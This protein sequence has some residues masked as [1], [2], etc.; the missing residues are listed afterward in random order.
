MKK[1]DFEVH[2]RYTVTLRDDRGRLR[3]ANFYVFRLYDGFMIA[4]AT[5][6]EGLLYKIAYDA[7]EKIVKHKAVP[8]EDQ[9]YI[10]EAVL[11]ENVWRDRNKMERYSTSPHMGK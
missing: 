3:P 6:Q 10:P 8:A 4:R 2:T 9:F 1:E 11:K 7:V 5:D